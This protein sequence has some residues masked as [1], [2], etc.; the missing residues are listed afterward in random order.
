MDELCLSLIDVFGSMANSIVRL[1]KRFMEDAG[2][3]GRGNADGI[4]INSADIAA[5]LFD[6]KVSE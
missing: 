2:G 1:Q 6:F 3:R 5:V 4:K